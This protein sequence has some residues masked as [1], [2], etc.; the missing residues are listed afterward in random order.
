MRERLCGPLTATRYRT[1]EGSLAGDEQAVFRSVL[2]KQNR[3]VD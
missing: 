3:G 2:L 1:G